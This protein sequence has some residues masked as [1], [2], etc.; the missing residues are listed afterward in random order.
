MDGFKKIIINLILSLLSSVIFTKFNSASI[1]EHS[2]SLNRPESLF[3]IMKRI[4]VV[5][6]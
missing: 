4:V 1:I 2:I 3:E 5:E 6:E